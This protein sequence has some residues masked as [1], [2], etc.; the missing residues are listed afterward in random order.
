MNYEEQTST[1]TALVVNPNSCGGMTG[2]NWDSLYNKIKG[3]FGENPLVSFN[4]KSGDGTTL[5]RD[6]LRRKFKKIVAFGGDGTV[7]EVVN[8]FFEE[9][10]SGSQIVD[11]MVGKKMMVKRCK[12]HL[13]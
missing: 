4:Q 8:G 7:N 9:I 11:H 3:I 2:K 10:S 6:L 13:S 12:R 5:T 1:E